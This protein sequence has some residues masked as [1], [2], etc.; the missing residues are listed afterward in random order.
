MKVRNCCCLVASVDKLYYTKKCYVIEFGTHTHYIVMSFIIFGHAMKT[1]K[2]Y[3]PR[4]NLFLNN[5][6]YSII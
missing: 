5:I 2:S 4:F 1:L 6:I 3:Y